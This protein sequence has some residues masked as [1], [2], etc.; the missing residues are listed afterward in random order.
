VR[1]ELLRHDPDFPM[2]NRL[3]SCIKTG[4]PRRRVRAIGDD[5]DTDGSRW[6]IQLADRPDARPPNIAIWGGPTE[7]AHA[8]DIESLTRG[9]ILCV[10]ILQ[11]LQ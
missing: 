8:L 10:S 7:L 4:N 2:K 6:L 9:R 1:D 11:K 3:P 5:R